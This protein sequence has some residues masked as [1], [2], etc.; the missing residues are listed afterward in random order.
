MWSINPFTN[1]NPIYSHTYNTWQYYFALT[2]WQTGHDVSVSTSVSWNLI[3]WPSSVMCS[4]NADSSN[5]LTS[6]S[7]ALLEKPPIVQLLKNFP[8]FYG[9]KGSLPWSHEPSTGPGPSPFVTFRNKLIFYNELLA[10]HATPKLEDH[11][12][13][14]VHDCLSNIF[15]ATLHIWRLSPPSTTWGCTTPWWQGTHLTWLQIYLADT[16]VDAKHVSC[17]LFLW[18]NLAAL[19]TLF[20][21][22]TE[23][24]KSPKGFSSK[25]PFIDLNT[26]KF[27]LALMWTIFV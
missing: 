20:H 3:W 17:A 8:A 10:S 15:V 5:W 25:S 26:C 27:S 22:H 21:I 1:P 13:S 24:C 11:P 23:C 9:P 12:L 18:L 14:A 19:Y 4:V 6:W 16:N 2:G 7:W